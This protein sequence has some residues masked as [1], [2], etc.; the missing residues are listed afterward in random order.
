MSEV[1]PFLLLPPSSLIA[2]VRADWG[3]VNL[4]TPKRSKTSFL[5]ITPIIFSIFCW[6]CP[7]FAFLG[8]IPPPSAFRCHFLKLWLDLI[9]T[10][11][12][13]ISQHDSP[14]TVH[15][16]TLLHKKYTF[17][18]RLNPFNK[19]AKETSV[20]HA[21]SDL[22]S[23]EEISRCSQRYTACT[24]FYVHTHPFSAALVV[25]NRR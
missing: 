13:S 22:N 15:N 17:V 14:T 11:L 1:P 23:W 19:N 20:D 24:T 12:S 8:E 21:K 9:Q 5:C 16:C 4:E 3:G 6:K 7:H 18:T 10:D 25:S 2:R